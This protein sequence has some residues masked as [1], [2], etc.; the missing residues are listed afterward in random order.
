MVMRKRKGNV[1]N[2][3]IS[4]QVKSPARRSRRSSC[5]FL[6]SRWSKP[7]YM[8]TATSCP[9]LRPFFSLR[10]HSRTR[11]RAR[12]LST[13]FGYDRTG[14]NTTLLKSRV[15]S[16]ICILI[17]LHEYRFPRTKIASISARFRTLSAFLCLC[18]GIS[19]PL[20]RGVRSV[21]FFL[22]GCG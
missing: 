1:I 8:T 5:A 19:Q 21:R 10:Q 16:R 7:G 14:T 11:R 13:A 6:S 18:P 4:I 3:F 20:P 9:G 15:F 17:P 12:F 2:R 22:V